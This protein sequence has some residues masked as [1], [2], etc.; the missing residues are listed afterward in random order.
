MRYDIY[1]VILFHVKTGKVLSFMISAMMGVPHEYVKKRKL[2][3][4]GQ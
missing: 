4:F 3:E 2:C 1:V